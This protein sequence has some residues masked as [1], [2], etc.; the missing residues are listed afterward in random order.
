MKKYFYLLLSISFLVVSGC[1]DTGNDASPR[2]N[3]TS[4]S[5]PSESAAKTYETR[6]FIQELVPDAQG[7]FIHHEE[8]P[9]FMD[10]MTMYLK[11]AEQDEFQRLQIGHQYEFDLMVDPETGTVVKNFKPTGKVSEIAQQAETPRERWSQAPTIELGDSSPD[12]VCTNT[13]GEE[14][15][16]ALLKDNV[17]AITFIF[18]RCP[19][20]DYCPLMTS[21]FKEAS[22][23][24]KG[25]NAT[26]WKL[27][28]ITI[29]PDHDQLNIL[30]DYRKA[31]EFDSG[32][33]YFCRAEPAELSKIADPLGLRFRADEFPI[34]HN[35]RTAVFDAEG[36]LVEVFSGNNW[37]AQQLVN[38]MTAAKE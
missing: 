35:L 14:V 22:E 19:L 5:S 9:G 10:E 16:S 33:V 29:D 34:E 37:T 15:R 25:S 38:S 11:V 28:S 4:A 31:W 17:W 6:G 26:N 30:N 12:F 24:L 36:K 8:I 1:G 18:T 7:A 27:I 3:D 13:N 32:N 23:L 21:R 2:E 20:P